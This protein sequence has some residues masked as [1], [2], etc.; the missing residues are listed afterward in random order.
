MSYRDFLESKRVCRQSYG[1]EPIELNKHL[2]DFQRD[3]V[4]WA[5]KKGQAAIF[6]DC[7]MG[8][9]LM[10]VCWANNVCLKTGGDVLI[11]S[12][13]AVAKQ[14]E[15]EAE[16]FGY[17]VKVCRKQSDCVHGINIT[18]YEMLQHFDAS[19]FVGMVLDE[20]SILKSYMGKTKQM[21]VDMFSRTPYRLACT[22]TPSPNDL[23]ELLNH[24][25]FLGIMESNKALSI[26]FIAE[27][28][29]S[30]T[31]RLK[32]H[33]Q[34]SFWQWV[35]SWAVALSKPSDIGDYSD[36]GYILPE[37]NEIDDVVEVDQTLESGDTLFRN[38]QTSAT[39][40]QHEK[41]ITLAERCRRSAEIANSTDAQV[42]VW[43]YRNDES[44]ELTRL[45]P[46]A[47]E[48][49]GSDSADF[50]EQAVLDFVDGKIRVLVSKPS[51]FGFG[52]NLQNCNEVIFCGMDYS[53]EGYYQ[54][55]RRCW[56]FGQ[57]SPVTVHRVLGET[58]LSILR[59]IETKKAKHKQMTES[60]SAH[61]SDAYRGVHYVLGE[62]AESV[63]IPDWMVDE[64][65]DN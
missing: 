23:M 54:A 25:E 3:I 51:I 62:K 1:F 48:V 11:V 12:P 44:T 28:N 61:V 52:V 60:I 6:A 58:E 40:Y 10:Q 14:T 65:Q 13:L 64:R 4:T 59:T 29:Q 41:K 33:A 37:L 26:W 21:I 30:G 43:C 9:T 50:K 16:K 27:Q 45:I 8:K 46:D 63:D 57:D 53:Y 36:D 49:K 24:A 18:N 35:A 56:R 17:T 34:E 39:G 2:F 42:L 5:C 31:Y 19:Q 20:S 38:V 55:V 32:G 47:T 22:A 15:R 7:G